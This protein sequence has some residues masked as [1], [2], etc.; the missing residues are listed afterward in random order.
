MLHQS[1]SIYQRRS[2]QQGASQIFR[3]GTTQ[4][5]KNKVKALVKALVKLAIGEAKIQNGQKRGERKV[6]T[7]RIEPRINYK[8]GIQ[9]VSR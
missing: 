1:K 4:E 6:T 9:Q 2:E 8:L 5:S 3:R 7:A